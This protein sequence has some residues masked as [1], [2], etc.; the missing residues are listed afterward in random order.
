[1]RK[2]I[3][4]EESSTVK[5]TSLLENQVKGQINEINPLESSIIDGLIQAAETHKLGEITGVKINAIAIAGA[6]DRISKSLKAAIKEYDENATK[7]KE[8]NIEDSKTKEEPEDEEADEDTEVEEDTEEI[9]DT[10]ESSSK[11]YRR[12]ILK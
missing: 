2:I 4:I 9:E 8:E 7:P 3:L 10:E 6:L 1:M 5:L 12:T 11:S